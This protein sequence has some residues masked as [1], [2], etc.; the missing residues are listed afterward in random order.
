MTRDRRLPRPFTTVFAVLLFWL[1][2]C[3]GA[4]EGLQPVP[5]PG[6]E[7]VGHWE[8]P[9][10]RIDI[11]PT[12]QVRIEDTT[13]GATTLSAPAR[14]WEGDKLVLNALIDIDYAIDERPYERDGTWRMVIDGVPLQ[15]TTPGWASET[16]GP[17]PAGVGDT[18]EDGPADPIGADSD[19]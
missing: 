12:G 14:S 16:D 10:L 2:G 8:G 19:G 13:D 17:L 15:R 7:W 3:S 11:D 9:G 6:P 18:P 1:L 5:P 4:L